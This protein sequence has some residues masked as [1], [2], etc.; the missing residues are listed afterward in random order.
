MVAYQRGLGAAHRQGS[1]LIADQEPELRRE[2]A[3]LFRDAGYWTHLAADDEEAVEIVHREAIDVV[4][5]ALELPR[6]GGLDFLRAVRQVIKASMPCVLTALEVSGRLQVRA[7]V[8]DAFTVVPKPLDG[9]VVV[10]AV[11]SALRRHH[12]SW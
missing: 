1:V 10:R 4:V 5:V 8:E 2:L 9:S 12:E 7:F 6:C 11:A 3:S